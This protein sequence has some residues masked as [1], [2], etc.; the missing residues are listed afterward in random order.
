MQSFNVVIPVT[1]QY[2]EAF[3]PMRISLLMTRIIDDAKRD[4]FL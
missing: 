2:K 4:G 1:A 3:P